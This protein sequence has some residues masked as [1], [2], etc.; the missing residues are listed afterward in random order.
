MA[1]ITPAMSGQTSNFSNPPYTGT[2]FVVV[3]CVFLPL[4]VIGL[5]V[6]TWTRLFI[7]RSFCADDCKYHGSQR[8]YANEMSR[9]DDYCSCG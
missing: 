4:A 3:N 8:E 9:F 6:R 7:V 5:V 1:S 2:K